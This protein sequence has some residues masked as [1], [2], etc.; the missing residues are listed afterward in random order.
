MKTVTLVAPSHWASYLLNGDDSGLLPTECNAADAWIDRQD[1]GLPV[2]CDDAGFRWYHDARLECPL[3]A[4]CQ[5]YVFI[6]G[7]S[8]ALLDPDFDAL[9]Y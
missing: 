1:M 6:T 2:S 3:G 8:V 4:D 5:E 7:H 9:T